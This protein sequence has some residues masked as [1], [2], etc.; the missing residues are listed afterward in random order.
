MI[1]PLYR[2]ITEKVR[3]K[4]RPDVQYGKGAESGEWRK[5]SDQRIDSNSRHQ[6]FKNPKK[7]QCDKH[8]I[9]SGRAG[10]CK[11][12][13]C[14]RLYS[15]D[16]FK[17]MEQA[18]KPQMETNLLHVRNMTYRKIVYKRLNMNIF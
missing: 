6:K 12:G 1:S 11:E 10:R 3:T 2:G 9:I 7:I 4:N 18:Q 16:D 5:F 17:G 8:I 14:F 15:N 13:F